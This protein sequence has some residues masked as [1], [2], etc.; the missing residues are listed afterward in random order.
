MPSAILEWG[1][2]HLGHTILAE[3]TGEVWRKAGAECL[4]NLTNA[5]LGASEWVGISFVSA[6]NA[7]GNAAHQ[8]G[9]VTVA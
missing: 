4:L 1:A 6:D 9:A 5:L 8:D 7:I 2:E 3:L